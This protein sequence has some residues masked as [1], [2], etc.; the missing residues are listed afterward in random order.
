MFYFTAYTSYY[1]NSYLLTNSEECHNESRQHCVK[2]PHEACHKE[3]VQDCK[4][5]PQEKN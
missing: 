5:V 1:N 4:T 2:I 3:P